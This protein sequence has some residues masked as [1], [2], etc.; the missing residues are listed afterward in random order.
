MSE[1]LVT[2]VDC[3]RPYRADLLDSCP[4]CGHDVNS[5]TAPASLGFSAVANPSLSQDYMPPYTR[6]TRFSDRKSFFPVLLNHKFEDFIFVRV[7]SGFYLWTLVISA[8]A[9]V[10]FELGIAINFFNGLA[11]ANDYSQTNY[12]LEETFWP[13]IGLIVGLPLAYLFELIVLRLILEAG[14]A[15][16]KIAENTSREN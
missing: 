4:G 11:V 7:A 16:I 5:Q 3:G 6:K 10:L 12:Y 9:L 8:I 14:V 13:F 2:C 15:L 1:N